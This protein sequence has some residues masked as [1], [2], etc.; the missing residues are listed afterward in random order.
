MA[1]VL[2]AC[3]IAYL[4]RLRLGQLSP[5]RRAATKQQM[6]AQQRPYQL[7][8]NSNGAVALGLADESLAKDAS[9]TLDVQGARQ[10]SLSYSAADEEAGR[11]PVA[12]GVSVAPVR[13]VGMARGYDAFA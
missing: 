4:A 7:S 12:I 10:H 1:A 6:R 13:A 2:L 9:A 8:D 11:L 3:L 5:R